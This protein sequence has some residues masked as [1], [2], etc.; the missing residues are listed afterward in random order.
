MTR[1]QDVKTVVDFLVEN[2]REEAVVHR[3]AHRPWGHYECIDISQRFKVK[4]ITVK[5]G[6]SLSLQK[7]FHRAEHWVVVKGNC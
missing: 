6:A 3:T 7:H 2:K 5:P 1:A 4:R